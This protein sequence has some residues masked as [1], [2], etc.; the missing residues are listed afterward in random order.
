MIIFVD[1][2]HAYRMWIAHHRAGFV[3]DAPRAHSPKHLVLHR[4]TC[5]EIK[6]SASKRTHWTTGNRMKLCALAIDELKRWSAERLDGT[7]QECPVCRPAAEV[8]EVAADASHPAQPRTRLGREIMAYVLDVAV[9]HLDNQDDEY[10][11]T[12]ADVAE[13]LSKSV[14]QLSSAVLRLVEDNDL[15]IAGSLSPGT[16]LSAR[17]TLVPTAKALRTVPAYAGLTEAQLQS[18]IAQLARPPRLS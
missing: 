5:P 7:P 1:E 10:H 11:L 18:L 8:I 14:R 6:H 4:A 15:S 13:Y 9:I 17:H 16:P 2:E 3:L 12:L